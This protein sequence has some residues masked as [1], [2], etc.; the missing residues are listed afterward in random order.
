LIAS[1]TA[2][3]T[4]A[5]MII[6]I[7]KTPFRGTRKFRENVLAPGK[8]NLQYLQV[9]AWSG[10]MPPQFGQD[11]ANILSDIVEKYHVARVN[12]NST[13]DEWV[14][15]DWFTKDFARQLL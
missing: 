10:Q 9:C 6:A 4:I 11:C 3:I 5:R 14:V 12:P 15:P 8:L 2:T 1:K 13:D 7:R